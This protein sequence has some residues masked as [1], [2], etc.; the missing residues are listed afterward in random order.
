MTTDPVFAVVGHPNKGKSSIV[1]TLVHNDKIEISSRS[2]TTQHAGKYHVETPKGGYKLVDT[3]GFQRPTKVLHWLKQHCDNASQRA[4]TIKQFVDDAHCREQFPDEVELLRPISEGAAILYVVDGS[5]PYGVEYE[6]EMDIL[7]WTGQ[8]SMALINPIESQAY[9]EEW[10]NALKQFFKAVQVFNP[11]LADFEKQM[12]LLRTFAHLSPSWEAHLLNVRTALEHKRDTQMLEATRALAHLLVDLCQ[13]QERQKVLTEGQA[14]TIQ[15]ALQKK[16]QIWMV[17]REQEALQALLG[18]YAHTQVDMEMASLALPPNLFDVDQWFVWG[19][20]KQALVVAAGMA[21]AVGGVAVDVA[22]AG[23]SLMLGA[24]GGGLLGA[25]SALLGAKKMVNARVTGLPLGGYEAV[26]GPVK[27]RNFPY[28]LIGRFL[29]CFRV[30][31]ERSHA[32]RD[33]VVIAPDAFQQTVEQLESSQ[34]KALHRACAS[35]IKQKAPANL[36]QILL[37]LFTSP[38]A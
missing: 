34:K 32:A 30:L 4:E 18:I 3:P 1:A 5:R 10:E 25:G 28:V 15:G 6:A 8:P 38:N 14:K 22:L 13:Y 31:S 37:P 7:R 17:N 11:M 29:Y 19:L 33:E 21:G 35:L 16:F 23:H 2:G 36:D 12:D 26:Y 20:D 24:V 9:V 27:N